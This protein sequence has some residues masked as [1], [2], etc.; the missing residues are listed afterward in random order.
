MNRKDFE[1]MAPVGSRE[2]LSA[3]LQAGAD[4]VYFGL[5]Q[6]NM[7]S[8]SSMNFTIEDLQEI[9]ACCRQ[10]GVRTYLTL[11]AVM[12]DQD[13]PQI[14]LQLEAASRCGVDAVIAS[15][16]SVV[17]AARSLGLSVHASTQL[18]IS[19]IGAVRF[20]AAYCDV[21]VLARELTLEQVASIHEAIDREQI[22]GP[23]GREVQIEM[24]CHGALCMAVSGKCY[25]SLHE[26][27][28]S[29]NRGGCLQVCRRG[30]EVRDRD[31]GRELHLENQYIMSPKDLCT[32]GFLDRMIQAGVRVFK[33]EGRARAPEYVRVVTECYHQ[34]LSAVI[35]ETFTPERVKAWTDRL[36]TVFNRGFWDGYY[37]G[38]KLGEWS[39]RYG[40]SATMRKEYVARCTN[41]FSKLGVAEFLVESGS[42]REGDLVL[43]TGDRFSVSVSEPVRRSDKLYKWVATDDVTP[44]VGSM[45]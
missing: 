42:V 36:D 10:A 2:S 6:L 19:N 21:M 38:Q 23:S 11:N 7:R 27:N 17:M 9:V 44:A 39:D 14:Q 8:A 1:I 29:A 18:N 25:L 32:L 41:Y 20:F 3:A 30:Y 34:A 28:R 24:F 15:D 45:L 33:I 31:T 5:G 37:L 12:Y 13:M 26:H 40:S 22:L 16:M 35:E 4:S 43:I